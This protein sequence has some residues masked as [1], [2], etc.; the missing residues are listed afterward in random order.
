MSFFAI[1]VALYVKL[2]SDQTPLVFYS[3]HKR[4]DLKRV[5]IAA[6]KRAKCSIWIYTY[7]LNDPH[8]LSLLHHKASHGVTCHIIYDQKTAPHLN[9]LET[10]HFHFHPIRERG[11]M[12]RKLVIID[13]EL[14]FLGSANLTTSSLA[15]HAN[16]LIGFF[17][18]SLATHF[19]QYAQYDFKLNKRKAKNPICLTIKNQTCELYHLPSKQGLSRLLEMLDQAKREVIIALFTFTHPQIVSKLIDLHKKGVVVKIFLDQ[20]SARGASARAAEQ[21]YQGGLDL[22]RNQGLGLLHYKWGMI[23]RDILIVGSANWTQAAFHYNRDLLLFLYPLH[24]KQKQTLARIMKIIERDC[25]HFEIS[26]SQ[27]KRSVDM[28]K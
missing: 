22:K 15:M 18:P 4:D 20:T 7:G 1:Y 21:L 16:C 25:L 12:H 3:S 2:P 13:S 26:N 27:V 23:D 10:D 24:K 8:I 28:L 14:L 5:I 9:R 19:I 6:I 17:S 11:L